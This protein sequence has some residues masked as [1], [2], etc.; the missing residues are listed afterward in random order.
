MTRETYIK[1]LEEK[2]KS[3]NYPNAD[4]LVAEYNRFYLMR[5]KN[6]E[7]PEEIYNRLG[8]PEKVAFSYIMERESKEEKMEKESSEDVY[9]GYSSTKSSLLIVFNSLI[10]FV[11]YIALWIF[12][13]ALYLLSVSLMFASVSAVGVLVFKSLE[14]YE[15]LAVGGFSMA[16]FS[17]GALMFILMNTITKAILKVTEKYIKL[18]KHIAKR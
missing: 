17:A 18:N 7:S 6:G 14:F 4:A 11:P 5:E 12:I 9:R 1:V 13:G 3:Y 16:L 2:L 15:K 10:I 8:P